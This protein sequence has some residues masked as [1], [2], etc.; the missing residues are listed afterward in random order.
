[1][2]I[3]SL[4]WFK[5]LPQK[6]QVIKQS[7]RELEKYMVAEAVHLKDSGAVRFIIYPQDLD[8]PRVLVEIAEDALEE[9]FGA[10]KNPKS[11]VNACCVHYDFIKEVALYHNRSFPELPIRLQTADFLLVGGPQFFPYR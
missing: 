4:G 5:C 8:G 11:W 3:Y 10:G 6:S 7:R 2:K 9:L 1:M